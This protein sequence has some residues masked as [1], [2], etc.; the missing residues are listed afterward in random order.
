MLTAEDLVN[1]YFNGIFPMADPDGSIYW[2]SPDPRAIIPIETYKPSKSLRP[3]INQ[4]IFEIRINSDF[5]GV[6]NG[7]ALP[8]GQEAETWISE[9]IKT[10]YTDLF[11]LHLAMSVEAYFENK[12]VGGL[13]GVV[14]GKVFF[15]ESMFHTMPN[16]SKVAFHYLMKYLRE[17]DFKL[18]DSQF[19]N[20]NVKRF[21]A[22]EIPKS[23]YISK[24]KNALNIKLED[25][26]EATMENI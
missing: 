20:D 17:N 26:F 1:G 15:G 12:L 21:G 23:V 9:E 25:M 6:V 19:I 5:E 3:V 2:Y 13:Y 4:N 16:A 18:L 8:R 14:M 11:N 10:A 22:I 7:C 24:L